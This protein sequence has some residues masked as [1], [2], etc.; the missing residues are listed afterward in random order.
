MYV[1]KVR[2]YNDIISGPAL[3][4]LTFY[5]NLILFPSLLEPYEIDVT[6]ISILRIRE[7][8]LIR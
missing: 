1:C 6:I 5:L 2:G 8:K 7:L 4:M 3:M